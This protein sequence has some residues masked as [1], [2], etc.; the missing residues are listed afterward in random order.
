MLSP[1]P[2][3]ASVTFTRDDVTLLGDNPSKV[4]RVLAE[5]GADVIGVNCSGG[6][7]Q[8]LRLL[9][10]MREAAPEARFVG[11]AQRRLAGAGRRAHHVS[12]R[13]GLLRRLRAVVLPGGRQHHRRLLRDDA[14]AHHVDARGIGQVPGRLP[15]AGGR[16]SSVRKRRAGMKWRQKRRRLSRRDW[17]PGSFPSPWR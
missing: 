16:D 4:A 13:C 6:P 2:V 3:V 10:A 9:K 12:C 14:R 15:A 5:E 11:E 1:L 8:L 17:P 7:S